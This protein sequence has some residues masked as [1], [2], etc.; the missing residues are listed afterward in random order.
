MDA[1]PPGVG[2][3][4]PGGR[5][6]RPPRL[7]A[8]RCR[9][10]REVVGGGGGDR[11]ARDECGSGC[12]PPGRALWVILEEP[13]VGTCAGP[14]G[15]LACGSPSRVLSGPPGLPG[16]DGQRR[17]PAAMRAQLPAALS[18]PRILPFDGSK[19]RR[20]GP[21]RIGLTR[22]RAGAGAA[23]ARAHPGGRRHD[24]LGPEGVLEGP[25]PDCFDAAT[26]VE[27]GG[28]PA[29]RTR[30]SAAAPEVAERHPQSG[31]PARHPGPGRLGGDDQRAERRAG[32]AL[33]LAKK[34]V[35]QP[36]MTVR[37]KGERCGRMKV[38]NS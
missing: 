9:G 24:P 26:Q 15:W 38:A 14:R 23:A 25:S 35:P 2:D 17:A 27:V 30:S 16:G 37:P 12:L 13:E 1:G 31:L 21:G 34:P 22:A 10:V 4:G 11:A 20:P 19:C 28:R 36:G 32:P 7:P 29:V 5:S 8:P 18:R 33:D 3:A 6:R